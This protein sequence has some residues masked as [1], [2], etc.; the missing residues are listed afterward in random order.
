MRRLDDLTSEELEHIMDEY[1]NGK[2]TKKLISDYML[3]VS[4]SQLYKH[5]PPKEFPDYTCK[6]CDIPMFANRKS[7]TNNS[8]FERDLYCLKCHHTL[9]KNCSCDNCIKERKYEKEHKLAMI[10]DV[11]DGH[12]RQ[13]INIDDISLE[14]KIYLGALCRMLCT[15]DMMQI[16]PYVS[17]NKDCSLTP[18]DRYTFSIIRSLINSKLISVSPFSSI[19]SFVDDDN[20]PNTYYISKVTYLIN[21]GKEDLIYILSGKFYD[22]TNSNDKKVALE[23]WK[24]IAVE[25]CV[26]YLTYSL[27]KAHFE[28]SAGEKTYKTF[29]DIL[30]NFSVSQIYGIIW[31]AVAD[32]SK[33]Y[34]EKK[35]P[36]KHAANTTIGS[37]Q[38]YAERAFLN[39]WKLSEYSRIKELPQCE[40]AAF[41]YNKVLKI[42]ELGFNCPPSNL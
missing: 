2:S 8:Y 24:R 35:L 31:R 17:C 7:K 1:Y 34:L 27:D 20:F 33:L 3:S 12:N 40:L 38:R 9:S 36:K 15:E 41:L 18:D 25:E 11:Y 42:G 26:Q 23:I 6:Y 16:S 39:S 28:F 29:E 19:D 10:A 30:D 13:I 4:P 37:C 32:A 14:N 22:E 5:F 21:V